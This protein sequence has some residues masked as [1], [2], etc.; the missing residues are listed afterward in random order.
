[1]DEKV[2]GV[3]ARGYGMRIIRGE[4]ERESRVCGWDGRVKYTDVRVRGGW[5]VD[6][7]CAVAGLRGLCDFSR[8]N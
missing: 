6:D 2:R 8:L 4:R 7:R 3:L 5:S 1:M